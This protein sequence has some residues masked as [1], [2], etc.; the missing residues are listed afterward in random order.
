MIEVININKY[1]N[2]GKSNELHVI[3]N[4]SLSFPEKGLVCLL[5]PSGSGKTTLLNII[6]GLDKAKNGSIILD[7]VIINSYNSWKW[8]NLRFKKIGYIFQHYNLID[9]KTVYENIASTLR[10]TYLNKSE[11][12]N[13]IEQ[14]L[15]AVGMELYL[16]HKTKYL[17]GGQSQRVAIARAIAK[18]PTIIIA[19]EPTGNL[20]EKNTL[21]IMKLLKKIS[22][23]CLVL[24]VTHEQRLANFF[25]DRI[26]EL[27]DGEVVSDVLNETK[28]DIEFI[29]SSNVYLKE[30]GKREVQ[31]DHLKV[32]YFFDDKKDFDL[33]VY[34]SNNTFYLD[35]KNV[36][37]KFLS[38]VNEI[39][40]IDDFKPTYNQV[41]IGKSEFELETLN[42]YK[43]RLKPLECLKDG[44]TH[45]TKTQK[46]QRIFFIGFFFTAILLAYLVASIYG[47]YV[48]N[49][50]SFLQ[51]NPNL[52]GS[53]RIAEYTSSDHLYRNIVQE[54]TSI[55]FVSS[56]EVL[57]PKG[58]GIFI[59]TVP[60]ATVYVPFTFKSYILNDFR[61]GPLSYGRDIQNDNEIILDEWICEKLMKEKSLN[62]AGVT[63]Y[64]DFIGLPLGFIN[65]SKEF[66]K[67]V[68]ISK[69]ETNSI[70]I[71]RD[72]YYKLLFINYYP[73][74]NEIVFEV[75]NSIPDG[76][77]IANNRHNITAPGGRYPILN[78]FTLE[79][80]DTYFEESAIHLKMSSNTLYRIGIVQCSHASFEVYSQNKTNTLTFLKDKGGVL[81]DF[82]EV[83]FKELKART[84]VIMQI[85]LPASIAIMAL[86]LCFIYF[87]MRSNLINRIID[88]GV[89]RCIGLR[90]SQVRKLFIY[91]IMVVIFL[92]VLPGYIISS[93][94]LQSLQGIESPYILLYYP[95]WLAVS[96]FLLFSIIFI[97]VGLIPINTLL[98]KTPSEI[99][100]KYDI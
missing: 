98:R 22:N 18:T 24:M 20:D 76:K 15:K 73:E 55:D 75:D 33:K 6:G 60:R 83:S 32:D 19:D 93:F 70:F 46:K 77:V 87:M 85:Q 36:R 5:G 26:I 95:W 48:P 25:A 84:D 74:W 17:S 94:I 9:Y 12:Q 82:Y 64:Q 92:F 35:P 62:F 52:I 11:I 66:G 96:G 67:I 14:S 50:H 79:L 89:Y 99:I 42:D 39:Q 61:T 72:F 1:Y 23:T 78:T 80:L 31:Q 86:S 100:F 4:I 54:N 29:D 91:E 88:I 97:L 53:E 28:E 47:V 34:Y 2:K 56:Y 45:V 16:N 41:S 8:D 37:A 30:M 7:N 10:L 43:P 71:N 68:G 13:R 90:K 58:F 69:S 49:P 44:Y 63:K 51:E 27:K 81:T 65:N 57:K 38:D 21:S 3:K 40:V 59:N